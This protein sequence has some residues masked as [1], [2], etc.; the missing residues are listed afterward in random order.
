MQNQKGKCN[1]KKEGQK[2]RDRERGLKKGR[3]GSEKGRMCIV[4]FIHTHVEAPLSHI[5]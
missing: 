1:N 2:D 3:L 4:F 5:F